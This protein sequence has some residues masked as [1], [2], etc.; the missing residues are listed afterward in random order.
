MKHIGILQL[1][2]HLDD[3]VHG[4]KDELAKLGVA[5]EYH[6][7]NADGQA[8]LLPKLAATLADQQVDL[9]F[10]CA[11]PSATAAIELPGNIPVV[12]TPVFDPVG[13]GLANS[14]EEPGGK[15]TG[16]A[17]M[18]SAAAKTA[19]IQQ[20]LPHTKKLAILYSQTDPNARLEVSL[21]TAHAQTV[22]ETV[23]V[24][25]EQ[26][27]EL[28]TLAERLPADCDAVFIPISRIIEE[29]FA[30]VVYYTDALSLPVIAS[31]PP[32]VAAGALGALVADHAQL[33]R[34]CAA[35]AA[36]ILAGESPAQIPIG[37]VEQPD[38][39]L[40]QY[41]AETLNIELPASLVSQAKE[42]IE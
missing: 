11:T 26:P 31:H 13:A 18:V 2:Q 9:I 4:F 39:W 19:F 28:S 37:F 5:A 8:A 17:G 3:A 10:A 30:S 38:I 25:I 16:A 34:L 40:N 33:G 22:W 32:N 42:I 14:L 7:L 27:E 15:A 21:F 29:N 12:Y 20:L 1:I 24:P 6:Y 36:A 41:A 35:K 23:L